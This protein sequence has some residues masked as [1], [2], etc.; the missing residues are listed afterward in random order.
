MP[1][2]TVAQAL[3][4]VNWMVLVALA[5]GSLAFVTLT[6][7]LTDATRGYLGFT[8]F[9]SG[10]L[11]VL[12]WAADTGLVEGPDLVIT[13]APA[14]V[15]L[16]RRLALGVVALS[17]LGYTL[18]AG[19]PARRAWLGLVGLIGGGAALA[20]AAVGWAP[21]LADAV[22]LLIQL[23]MLALATGGA[24]AAIV[25]AHWYLVTPRI[26]ERPLLLQARL[27]TGVIAVQLALFVVWFLF[28]G[29]PGQRPFETLTGDQA[30]F[31]WLRLLVGLL[32]P[33]ALA[34]MA[35][36]T[37]RTRSMESATGLLYLGLAAI[38]SG[39]IGSAALYVGT[40][41]L[42]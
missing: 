36:A 8:A 13:P 5:V 32:F 30:L 24:L 23:A 18:S 26:S 3:P 14:E 38:V 17:S 15:D 21:A 16:V 28:G 31:G 42:L 22:P 9:C 4:Y 40:G 2:T 7:R 37:A 11:A 29:G 19:R 1:I 35:W 27:L 12:A 6:G 39:T 25:L 41:L 34:W 10:L 33:L 20:A